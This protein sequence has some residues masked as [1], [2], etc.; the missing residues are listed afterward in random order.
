MF[1]GVEIKNFTLVGKINLGMGIVF[2]IAALFLFMQHFYNVFYLNR[3]LLRFRSFVLDFYD[4]FQQLFIKN[5]MEH[6]YAFWTK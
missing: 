1:G 6:D 5:R 2:I 4:C 3:F